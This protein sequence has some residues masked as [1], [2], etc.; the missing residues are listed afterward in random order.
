[1]NR[2]LLILLEFTYLEKDKLPITGF[3]S[4][5]STKICQIHLFVLFS[6]L[7]NLNKT[8]VDKSYK[9]GQYFKIFRVGC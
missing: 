4:Q 6:M 8:D 3:S 9:K 7:K 2:V 5:I 1:M